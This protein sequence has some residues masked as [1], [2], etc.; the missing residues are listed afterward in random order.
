MYHKVVQIPPASVP[1]IRLMVNCTAAREA[2]PAVVPDNALAAAEITRHLL[3]SRRRI[4]FLNLS[5]TVAGELRE[6]GFRAAM[7]DAGVGPDG[8]W[9]L[10]AA[11]GSHS[12][13][14]SPSL[15]ARH[16]DA[17]MKLPTPPD[18]ILAGND[19][20]ALEVYGALHRLGVRIPDDV[21]V[22]SFDNNV[23]IAT[24]LDPPLTTMALPHRAIG[25]LAGKMLLSEGDLPALTKIPFQL[26][27]RHSV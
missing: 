10:P 12:R 16:L 2:L 23:D 27:E 5:G 21:A 6:A 7:A 24:R 17:L 4:A 1:A 13:R 26:I 14:N 9:I 3:A 25:R 11:Q 18:A 19:R 15:V 20:V 22:G 8:F